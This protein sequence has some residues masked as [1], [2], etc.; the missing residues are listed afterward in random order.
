MLG[1]ICGTQRTTTSEDVRRGNP[2]VYRRILYVQ[3]MELFY[4]FLADEVQFNHVG[5]N[6]YSFDRLKLLRRIYEIMISFNHSDEIALAI[7]QRRVLTIFFFFFLFIFF[8]FFLFKRS[9]G[10]K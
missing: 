4:V 7:V 10:A 8:I 6:V 9:P 5:G 3:A 2:L 1:L